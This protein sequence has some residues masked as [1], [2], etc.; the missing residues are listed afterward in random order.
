M[1]P[2]TL[3]AFCEPGERFETQTSSVPF[4]RVSRIQYGKG[5]VSVRASSTTTIT[6]LKPATSERANRKL[7]FVAEADMKYAPPIAPERNWWTFPSEFVRSSLR[8]GHTD[9][10]AELITINRSF[11]VV[12][13][14]H[15]S[16]SINAGQEWK[17][18]ILL[19]SLDGR[20]PRG[21]QVDMTGAN[22]SY[23]R[24]SNLP[25]TDTFQKCALTD[26]GESKWL[27]EASTVIPSNA[28]PDYFAIPLI[29]LATDDSDHFAIPK[30]P[31][32]ER[33]E[34]PSAPAPL[35]AVA[36]RVLGLETLTSHAGRPLF[37]S[38]VA[39]FNRP[40]W[41]EIDFEGSQEPRLGHIELNLIVSDG[42]PLIFVPRTLRA[43]EPNE[44]LLA[45]ETVKI[46]G[47]TRLRFQLQVPRARLA[48]DLRGFRFSRFYAPTS[49]FS[50]SELEIP[51]LSEGWVLERG[52]IQR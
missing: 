26:V 23:Q 10:A 19:K 17:T 7:A 15:A 42:G 35:K 30:R 8:A 33:V 51:S 50:W 36:W 13:V 9:S 1:G 14:S 40:F 12:S 27:I 29:R 45:S 34:N 39:D 24:H 2:A 18:R 31:V 32:Y 28:Q 44:T 16:P 4:W 21:C 22:W 20:A 25:A 49:D 37:N 5:L 52:S 11:N 38:H 46:P 48:H 43:D 41:L 3:Q 6:C 47:G